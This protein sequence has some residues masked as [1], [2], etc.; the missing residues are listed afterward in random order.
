MCHVSVHKLY[1]GD[2]LMGITLYTAA[3]AA[4]AVESTPSGS[5]DSGAPESLL[6]MGYHY[7][8]GRAG[9]DGSLAPPS[10]FYGGRSQ[11]CCF[12]EPGESHY[13]RAARTHAH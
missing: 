9:E 8:M 6:E 4:A 11:R 3:A 10:R 2:M 13:S 5:A 1:A 12:S 7:I